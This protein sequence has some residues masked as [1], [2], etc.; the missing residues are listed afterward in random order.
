MNKP[1]QNFDHEFHE[2]T[3]LKT[4]TFMDKRLIL[5]SQDSICAIRAIRGQDFLG[6][7]ISLTVPYSLDKLAILV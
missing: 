4:S 5:E 7:C 1:G 2:C 3:S 6:H